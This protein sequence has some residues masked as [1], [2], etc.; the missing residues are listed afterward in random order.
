MDTIYA[1]AS[2]VG[3]AGVAVIRV[4]GP[5]AHE[6]LRDLA[7][8]V[9]PM[10]YMR[11]A[12]LHDCNGHLL[13][14]AL[15]VAFPE[16]GSFTGE[17]LAELHVHGSPAVTTAVMA[18]LE[19]QGLARL[20]E[21]G[22]FTRRALL[23]DKLSLSEVEGL[24]DLVQAE[25]E[26]QRRQALTAMDGALGRKVVGWRKALV[27]TMALL[28][29][30]IDFA[31]EDVPDTVL[32]EAKGILVNLRVELAEELSGIASAERVR[33][34]VSVAILGAPN[35]GKSTLLN[36]LARRDVALTS[37]IAGTTRDVIEVRLDLGGV[38][39]RIFDTAG[40]RDT[41]DK[42]ERMGVERARDLAETVDVRLLLVD[43]QST[44]A[45]LDV[46]EGDLRCVAKDDDGLLPDGVSGRT[47]AGLPRVLGHLK[48]RA[49]SLTAQAGSAS[50]QRHRLALSEA[51][52]CLDRAV[53]RLDTSEHG[54]EFAADEVR[55]A[56]QVLDELVGSV[57]VEDVLDDIFR[58]FCLGK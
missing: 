28:S 29:V 25:T 31:D 57:D 55:H 24:G 51:A 33:D 19:G 53:T 21:P 26:A 3:K 23:N 8:V 22:E 47:G 2:G 16:K 35:L 46:R 56:V 36:A 18:A 49:A 32:H 14:Q 48:E 7:G 20:A 6:A 15:V 11:L 30:T 43:A 44:E 54:V 42:V 12:R 13:D 9:P 1:L 38:P 37:E 27:H 45:T 10:R 52:S 40:L 41:G 50:N 39:V 58:N 17:K 34:G 5:G 4:S